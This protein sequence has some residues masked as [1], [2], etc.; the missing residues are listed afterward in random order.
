MCIINNR[1]GLLNKV[2]SSVIAFSVLTLL[3]DDKILDQSKLKAFADDQL[4]ITK[5]MISVLN[6]VENLVGKGEIGCTSN[7][8][9][10]NNVFK[11]LLSQTRQ[12]VSSCGYG[13]KF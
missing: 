8:S 13:L 11:R 4:N 3:P 2:M 1:K 10:F 7:S 12:N 5:I 9:F 6:R